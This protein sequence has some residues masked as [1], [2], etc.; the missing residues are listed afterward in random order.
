[1]TK[2]KTLSTYLYVGDK[3]TLSDESVIRV[4]AVKANGAVVLDITERGNAPFKVER[5]TGSTR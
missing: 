3:V 5:A 2:G 4:K 1:M